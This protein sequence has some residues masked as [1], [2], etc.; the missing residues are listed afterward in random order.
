MAFGKEFLNLVYVSNSVIV[1]ILYT[2]A[3]QV[4]RMSAGGIK[5]KILRR[6]SR[7]ASVS[8]AP[9]EHN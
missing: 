3:F 1:A 7:G 5:D 8:V 2:F 9:V 6:K 4:K